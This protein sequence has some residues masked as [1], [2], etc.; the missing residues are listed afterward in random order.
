MFAGIRK[1]IQTRYLFYI[2]SMLI[3]LMLVLSSGYNL[4][5]NHEP[6]LKYHQDCSAYQISLL[7]STIIVYYYTFGLVLCFLAFI[8]S[9]QYNIVY[10][11]FKYT[12]NSRAPPFSNS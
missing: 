11:F 6:D 8:Y 5:H 4:L 1:S 3:V 2:L 10:S 9:Y 12:F 7:L